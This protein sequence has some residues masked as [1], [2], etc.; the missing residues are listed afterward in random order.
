MNWKEELIIKLSTLFRVNLLGTA[1]KER[2][3]GLSVDFSKN[4]ELFFLNNQ[5]LK[6][7]GQKSHYIFF[8]VGQNQGEYTQKLLQLDINSTIH[9]FEPNALLHKHLTNSFKS[10]SSV[11]INNVGLSS[12]KEKKE[13]YTYKKDKTSG[14]GS[15]YEAVFKELHKNNDI[16]SQTIELE[17]LDNYCAEKNI[18]HI[19][20]LKIDVEGNEFEVLN[21]AKRILDNTK[22]VQF[23][24]NEMNIINRVFLKDF[25]DRLNQFDIYRMTAKG[26][27]SLHQ[28]SSINEIFRIQ[29][30]VAINRS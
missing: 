25:Y 12:K 28:Y 2:G 17:T 7:L 20:L 27:L 18:E 13:L 23:E 5:L 9:G 11:Q 6:I 30:I 21:G 14:H 15:I 24:F 1:Y 16:E 3:I 10:Y 8:D 26:L 22:V 29:N 19:D 4:G